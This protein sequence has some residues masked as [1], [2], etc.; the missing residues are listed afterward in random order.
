[1]VKVC[2]R[3]WREKHS[4]NDVVLSI[5]KVSGD[6]CFI[7]KWFYADVLLNELGL[8]NNKVSPTYVKV[9]KGNK[10]LIEDDIHIL[11]TRFNMDV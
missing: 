9:D 3:S 8:K 6:G 11:K 2:A 1:M 10:N 5:N 7:C 4:R